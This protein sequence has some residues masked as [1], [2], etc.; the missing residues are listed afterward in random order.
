MCSFRAISQKPE[1]QFLVSQNV[2]NIIVEIQRVN[3]IFNVQ[4]FIFNWLTRRLITS[5]DPKFGF[6]NRFYK[7]NIFFQNIIT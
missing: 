6:F 5:H 7:V 4:G 2:E 1:I 3:R